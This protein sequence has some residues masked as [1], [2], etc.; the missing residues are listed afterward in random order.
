MN[1][2]SGHTLWQMLAA[3]IERRGAVAIAGDIE[4][5]DREFAAAIDRIIG[6]ASASPIVDMQMGTNPISQ[7]I[8]LT[9]EL[10]D[11]QAS[12]R[13]AVIIARAIDRTQGET[14]G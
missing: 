4:A 7:I 2:H 3:E 8:C 10:C 1:A 9:N 6:R 5:V 13:R 14:D 12:V 11:A